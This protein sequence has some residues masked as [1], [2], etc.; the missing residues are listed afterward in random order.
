[1]VYNNNSKC[2]VFKSDKSA[3]QLA[4][5]LLQHVF[6]YLF[7]SFLSLRSWFFV[8]PFTVFYSALKLQRYNCLSPHNITS[9]TYGSYPQG[10]FFSRRHNQMVH[11]MSIW[12][13]PWIHINITF[14]NIIYPL[15][16]E[17]PPLWSA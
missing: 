2:V 14:H 11:F 5:I 15:H 10:R 12:R 1:M 6:L 9:A 4:M 3:A 17:I 13:P 8:F 7:V 16:F